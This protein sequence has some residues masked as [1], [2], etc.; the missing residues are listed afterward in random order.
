[1]P[2]PHARVAVDCFVRASTLVDQVDSIIE[3]L[4][5]YETHG[6]IDDLTVEVWPDEI[7][8]TATPENSI[9][10]RYELFNAWAD[11]N[12]VDLEPAFTTREQTTVVDDEPATMLVLPVV[13]L[14]VHVGG[15]LTN[16]VPHRISAKTY[17]VEQAL[18][19]LET[20][21]RLPAPMPTTTDDA[22]AET[23]T[24]ASTRS[25][26][27]TRT[28]EQ[29][30]ACGDTLVTGQGLYACP[31]CAWSSLAPVEPILD[32]LSKATGSAA[33]EEPTPDVDSVEGRD[34]AERQPAE[35]TTEEPSNG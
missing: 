11:Q 24:K 19:D 4:R 21:D 26:P 30:P 6:V 20:L 2:V 15:I 27:L 22:A 32:S 18:E 25:P 35:P 23:P 7:E 10:A 29:C 3:R 28:P 16:V 9:L 31:T 12:D 13:C 14:A 5:D 34:A 33:P 8:L 1:M 17:T